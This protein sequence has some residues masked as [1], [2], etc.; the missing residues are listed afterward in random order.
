M[1]F[2]V[3]ALAL[4]GALWWRRRHLNAMEAIASAR[5]RIGPTGV[6][7]GGEAFVLDRAGAPAILLL[8][9]GG[10]TPQSLRYLADVLHARGFHVSAPLLPGH[11]RS[12]R[13]FQQTTADALAAAVRDEYTALC[14]SHDWVAV[15]GL[16]MGGAL[17]VPLAAHTD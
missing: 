11:G 6:V 10:D 3:L 15:I 1:P 7:V 4:A 17:A 14:Q 9:G 5:R 12:I 2:F 8:H 16:S 13:D